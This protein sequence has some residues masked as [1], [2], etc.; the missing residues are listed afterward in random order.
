MNVLIM[1]DAFKGTLSSLELGKTMQQVFTSNDIKS[2]YL[3]ISDGGEGFHDAISH[4]MN[5]KSKNI[6]ITDLDGKKRMSNYLYNKDTAYIEVAKLL[7]FVGFKKR[8]R[9]PLTFTSKALGEMLIEIH[10]NGIKKVVIGLGGSLTNDFGLGVISAMGALF[11]DKENNIVEPI[12][13]STITDVY[14]IDL[15]PLAIYKDLEIIIA[16]DVENP[17]LGP[18]GATYTFAMQKGASMEE[19]RILEASATYF[20]Y[21]LTQAGGL[22][23]KNDKGVGAAGGIAY[24]LSSVFNGKIMK[25]MDFFFNELYDFKNKQKAYDLIVTGEGKIDEQSLYGKVCFEVATHTDKPVILV[26]A[27]LEL[28]TQMIKDRFSNVMGVYSIVP[29][30]AEKSVSIE[31][32]HHYFEVLSLNVLKDIKSDVW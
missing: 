29:S 30:L 25:G 20:D 5:V 10:K 28:D 21:L 19:Q 17:L 23:V 26:S 32:A 13:P 4:S 27:L 15:S 9:S 16:S 8:L 2:D 11:Y 1:I 22:D 6:F 14:K 3:P 18:S 7:G 24:V 31:H 12:N